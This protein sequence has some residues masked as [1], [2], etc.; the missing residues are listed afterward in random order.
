MYEGWVFRS[1]H[2]LFLMV[3]LTDFVS[4]GGVWAAVNQSGDRRPQDHWL[5]VCNVWEEQ[6]YRIMYCET[7]DMYVGCSF[8]SGTPLQLESG[9]RGR[10]EGE[11]GHKVGVFKAHRCVIQIK[12]AIICKIKT[13]TAWHVACIFYI[14]ILHKMVNIT[15]TTNEDC[16]VETLVNTTL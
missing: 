9:G 16:N 11:R 2:D 1:T 3:R 10:E 4:G 15:D 14:C 12:W 5:Q 6:W 8:R 7:R 13:I